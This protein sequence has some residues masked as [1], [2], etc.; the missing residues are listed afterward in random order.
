MRPLNARESWLALGAAAVLLGAWGWVLAER[1]SEEW[2]DLGE[3][4]DVLAGQRELARRTIER[5]DPAEAR[6]DE[7]RARLP[8]HPPD[9]DVTAELLRAIEAL[10]ERRGLML[11][12][13]EPERE[14]AVDGLFE[15]SIHCTWEGTLDALVAFLYAVQTHEAMLD[16]QQLTASPA[17]GG[18]PGRLR[19]G[20]TVDAA[21][22]RDAPR[23]APPP[24]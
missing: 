11:T 1:R 10:A 4:R 2:R 16:I 15:V 6:L 14:R 22:T 19:G 23:E 3:R 17:P 24:R 8:N 9:R 13:R 20:F 18:Q 5:R 7:L 21:Y 12:R